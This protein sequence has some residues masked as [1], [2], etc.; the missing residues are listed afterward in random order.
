MGHFHASGKRFAEGTDLAAFGTVQG[1]WD[2]TGGEDITAPALLPD[3]DGNRPFL[4]WDTGR[5]VTTKRRVVW[6]FHHGDEWS[7]WNATAWYGPPGSGPHVPEVSATAYWVGTGLITPTPIQ[8]PPASSFVNGPNA[9]QTAWPYEGNDHVVRT[10]W[11]P[12]TLHMLDH[13][14]R[15]ATDPQLNFSSVLEL[16]PGGDDSGYCAENDDDVTSSSGITGLASL[17]TQ[18][19]TFAHNAGATLLVGYV[20]PA[21]VSFRPPSGGGYGVGS[22]PW[23]DRGDPAAFRQIVEQ[24]VRE[25]QD[26]VRSAVVDVPDTFEQLLRTARELGPNQLQSA[27]LETKAL[28]GRGEAALKSLEAMAK[29]TETPQ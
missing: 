2:P 4:F 10:E 22:V 23:F 6:T 15:G 29:R 21:P 24:A 25:L 20:T 28:L 8:A 14:Q 5:R 1:D 27:I 9:G 18:S 17:G 19:V 12:A 11:G 13:V 26:R 16:V 7:T 3:T